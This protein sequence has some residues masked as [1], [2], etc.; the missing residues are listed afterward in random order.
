MQ[1]SLRARL[2]AWYSVLLVLTVVVFSAAVLW[3]HW[4]LLL[5]QFD[6][7]LESI[8]ATASRVVEAELAEEDSLALAAAEMV[9]V[10]RPRGSSCRSSTGRDHPSRPRRM[11]CRCRRSCRLPGSGASRARLR[12]LTA[13]RGA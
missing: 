1:L 2:T 5:E 13:G 12:R 10:V 9:S 4:R 11:G 6:E 8:S 7:G 3:L